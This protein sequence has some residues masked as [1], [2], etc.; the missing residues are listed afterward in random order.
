MKVDVSV[1]EQDGG[2]IETLSTG[3]LF[4]YIAPKKEK[5][6]YETDNVIYHITVKNS[7]NPLLAKTIDVTVNRPYLKTDVKV[8]DGRLYYLIY[9][10]IFYKELLDNGGSTLVYNGT[11]KFDRYH[12]LMK[13]YTD[14]ACSRLK[15]F[16]EYYNNLKTGKWVTYYH[17]DVTNRNVYYIEN[18]SDGALNGM[19]ENYSYATGA[20]RQRGEYQN[21]KRINNWVTYNADGT[22]KEEGPYYSYQNE[23]WMHKKHGIWTVYKTGEKID[24]TEEYSFDIL[25]KRIQY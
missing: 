11:E 9:S 6:Y 15:F 4:K 12:G 5:L 13:C 17:D 20:L 2:S 7:A 8:Y 24:Y 1:V 3:R 22:K 18:F 14:E 19:Y 10:G 23:I 16:G 21:N 25:I